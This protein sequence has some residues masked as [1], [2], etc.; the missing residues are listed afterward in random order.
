[1][2][3]AA[4]RKARARDP[5]QRLGGIWKL[6]SNKYYMDEIYGVVIRPDASIHGEADVTAAHKADAEHP[7]LLIRWA[8]QF[9]NLNGLIDQRMVDG[10]VNF[11]ARA[12]EWFSRVN[13]WVDR[14]VVDATVLPIFEGVKPI[15]ELK[16]VG[17]AVL[18]G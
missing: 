18:S 9:G 14:Y 10:L 4:Q 1:M 12:G 11:A 8:D 3:G 2:A 16:V 7:G 15:L 17:R 13:G 5:L 6:L